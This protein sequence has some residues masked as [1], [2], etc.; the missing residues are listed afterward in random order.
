MKNKIEML[1]GYVSRALSDVEQ[2]YDTYSREALAILFTIQNS[3]H[4][5][6][7]ENS[8]Y[9][10]T[11]NHCYTLDI[12]QIQ[13]HVT[14]CIINNI[15]RGLITLKGL[16][17]KFKICSISIAKSQEICNV[18]WVHIENM[19][20]MLFVDV[21]TKIIICLGEIK[22]IPLQERQ[23][24][25]KNMHA[26]AIGGHKGILKTM[27][28]MRPVYYWKSNMSEKL[29][30]MSLIGN[31]ITI[32]HRYSER[33]LNE[34]ILDHIPPIS[35]ATSYMG[36]FSTTWFN[37]RGPDDVAVVTRRF[38][39]IKEIIQPAPIFPFTVPPPIRVKQEDETP[40]RRKQGQRIEHRHTP[41]KQLRLSATEEDEDDDDNDTPVVIEKARELIEIL[42]KEEEASSTSSESTN[43]LSKN[44]P[45]SN[46]NTSASDTASDEDDDAS[47][48][49]GD[50]TTADEKGD[51]SGDDDDQSRSNKTTI[52]KEESFEETSPKRKNAPYTGS[53]RTTP[54]KNNAISDKPYPSVCSAIPKESWRNAHYLYQVQDNLR[55]NNPS[56]NS[57]ANNVTDESAKTITTRFNNDRG[58]LNN[59]YRYND[60]INDYGGSNGYSAE[61]RQPE[62]NEHGIRKCYKCRLPG[63]YAKNC[64]IKENNQ[65]GEDI[66]STSGV[67]T[68]SLNNNSINGN[69]GPKVV[70]V[71]Y[72]DWRDNTYNHYQMR[73]NLPPNRQSTYQR[74][75]SSNDEDRQA[76]RTRINNALLRLTLP[77]ENLRFLLFIPKNRPMEYVLADFKK[78]GTIINLTVLPDN[79]QRNTQMKEM[80][81]TLVLQRCKLERKIIE[82]ALAIA[83]L[84]PSEL[85]YQIL[86]ERGVMAVPAGECVHFVTCLRVN[87][88]IRDTNDCYNEIPVQHGNKSLFLAPR[89]RILIA[90]G[91]KITCDTRMPPMFKIG[92]IWYRMLPDLTDAPTPTIIEPQSQTNWKYANTD[93]LATGGVYS[94]KD[95]KKYRDFIV[96]PLERP[97]VLNQVAMT[98]SGRHSSK[99]GINIAGFLDEAML[100]KIANNT[101]SRIYSSFLNFGTV[102]AGIIGLIMV[103]RLIKLCIDATIRSYV[104]YEIF[105]FS[106][107]LFGA[108]M[109]SVTALL[110]HKDTRREKSEDVEQ[111]VADETTPSAPENQVTRASLYPNLDRASI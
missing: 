14:P 103:I 15:E 82:N 94:E 47:S 27:R 43:D 67:K 18:P 25:L 81:E 89:S 102:S 73:S 6:W 108:I 38:C 85:A 93:A 11:I 17:E 35:I 107:K 92:Q 110:I 86:G 65:G 63:H 72:I 3:K 39:E 23:Q 13:I 33:E 104:L 74:V 29:I 16:M 21:E 19:L 109:A 91:K 59:G 95:Q 45:G 51:S 44:A 60:D 100:E 78:F 30:R 97:S 42:D 10:Q 87:L 105:G 69:A 48:S 9:I 40:K 5:Y 34:K 68:T 54:F 83:T 99:E 96:F 37:I 88:E 61:N 98:V 12:Q 2:K 41:P 50:G 31:T 56:K 66:P 58:H 8:L 106:F 32:D 84:Q 76:S 90:Y 22:F 52:I 55:S 49:E 7:A 79:G 62:S 24:I 70:S 80:Y 53:A 57:R 36:G 46:Q 71:K 77:E 20:K 4:T 64:N 111:Q 26:S 101:W 75:N 28:R 1:I